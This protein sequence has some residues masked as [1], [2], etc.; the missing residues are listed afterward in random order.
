VIR[1][2]AAYPPLIGGS[3]ARDAFCAT[4]WAG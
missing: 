3:A 4:H 2:A 1:A